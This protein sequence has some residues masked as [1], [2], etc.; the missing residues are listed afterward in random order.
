MKPQRFGFTLIELLVVIAIIA[1]L[2]AILFPVFASARQKARQTACLSNM[3]QIGTADM[4][5]T[6]DNDEYYPH[7]FQAWPDR[8]LN[9]NE[10]TYWPMWALQLYP[11]TKNPNIVVCPNAVNTTLTECLPY[12]MTGTWGSVCHVTTSNG[13]A[14]N[15]G[16]AALTVPLGELGINQ[17]IVMSPHL[18]ATNG[19]Y[20]L[21]PGNAY[22][23]S[24]PMV[25]R[26]A[27]LPFAADSVF[28]IF[29]SLN[30]IQYANYPGYWASVPTTPPDAATK[31]SWSR[32]NGGSNICFGDG[33]AK[34][35][36]QDAIASLVL[37]PL[38]S[39]L[40]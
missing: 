1:I 15:T 11:Y 8:T 9:S 17:Y 32:H 2:A 30:R 40:Q 26:P 18:V 39:R 20:W 24:L 29:P 37:D 23:I 3:K 13:S 10:D 22:P 7:Y 27:E 19:G 33:H 31:L 16:A 14:A 36:T 6:Q 34:W 25:G 21:S 35:M 28:I 38:D 12:T 5:Y 4:M